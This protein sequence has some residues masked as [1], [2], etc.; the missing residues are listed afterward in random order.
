MTREIKRC[1][2]LDATMKSRRQRLKF[3]CHKRESAGYIAIKHN[4]T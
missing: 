2:V 4:Q 3:P 1:S